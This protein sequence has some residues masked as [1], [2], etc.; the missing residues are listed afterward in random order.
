MKVVVI[1]GP[2]STGKSTLT[3]DLARFYSAKG[4]SEYARDYVEHLKSP[5]TIR[6]VET[7][8]CRQI[9]IYR[10]N[11]RKNNKDDVVFFDTFLVIT[12]VW[13]Q[14]VYKLCPIWLN[15]AIKEFKPNLVL[16][17]KPDI[18]WTFDGVRENPNLREY[19]FECYSNE[20]D[21]Y[22]INYR[23]VEGSGSDRLKSAISALNDFGIKK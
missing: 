6:D 17:C 14:E 1:S 5:Y 13:F 7:I 9:A 2:E 21:F 16:L 22:G 20:F 8:A 12:K 18:K 3:K 11:Q 15:L 10:I 19:L 23:F 4:I